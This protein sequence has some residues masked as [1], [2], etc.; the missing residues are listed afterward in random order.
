ME[1]FPYI[2]PPG[3]NILFSFKFYL[4][5]IL[6]SSVFCVYKLIDICSSV[7]ILADLFDEMQ[8]IC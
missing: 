1:D 5:Q 2:S 7:L 4:L 8:H 6:K 3:R